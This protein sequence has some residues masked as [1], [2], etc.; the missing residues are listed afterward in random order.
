M[1]YKTAPGWLTQRERDLLYDLAR[2]CPPRAVIV[3]VGVEYGA[4]MICLSEGNPSA[5][6]TGIDLDCSK[7]QERVPARM[8]EMDSGALALT[9]PSTI[10]LLFVDGDHSA[11]GV[12]RDI[13]FMRHVKPGGVAAF[14]DCYSWENPRQ[15]HVIVPEVNLIVSEW[16]AANQSQWREREPVDSIR[17][18]ERLQ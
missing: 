1:S 7:M 9:W 8:L 14:H 6:L 2:A 15:P 10:D 18:F 17:I 3:N 11:I 12:Q 5:Q 13:E 16:Y 4:S